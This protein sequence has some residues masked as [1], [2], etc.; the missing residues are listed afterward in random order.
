MESSENGQPKTG[1]DEFRAALGDYKSVASLAMAG[2][3]VAPLADYAIGLGPPWPWAGG[4]PISTSIVELLTL[5]CVFHFWSRSGRKRSSLQMI[6]LLS[7]LVVFFGSYLYFNS[8]YIYFSPGDDQK[9]VKGFTIRDDVKPLISS[10]YTPDDALRDAE[11]RAEEVWT[12]SSITTMRLTLLS[13]WLASFICLSAAIAS[14]VLYHRRRPGRNRDV[15]RA[16]PARTP[17]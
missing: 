11:Y 17:R 16:T 12:A 5:I 10:D 4:V 7:L 3:V 8:A 13:L 6:L 14:F 1:L 15:T 2:G 9:H